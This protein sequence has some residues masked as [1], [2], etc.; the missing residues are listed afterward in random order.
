MKA[1]LS[2]SHTVERSPEILIGGSKSESNRLLIL[3]ALFPS[4]QINNLSNSDD[5]VLLQ[6]A[7]NSSSLIKDIHHA[8]TAMRFLTAYYA[9]QTG[10]EVLLTGSERM[11]ERPIKILVDALGSLGAEISYAGK[12]G[13]PPLKITG[14]QLSGNYVEL[15]AGISSQFISALMLIAP[16]LKDGLRIKLKGEV[17]S[18]PYL[19]MTIALLN[20]CGISAQIS[21]NEIS[22]AAA[23]SI[24]AGTISVESDWSSASYFYSLIALSDKQS[25]TL[26][27]FNPESRQGDSEVAA[28]YSQL[29]ITTS[30]D[31]S[32]QGITL[33]QVPADIPDGLILDLSDTPDIA[34]TIAISCFGLGIG[35]ELSGLHTLKIKETDRLLALKTEL[36]KL[37]GSVQVTANSLSLSPSVEFREDVTVETY[38]DHRMAMAFAPLAQK[39]NIAVNDAGVVSKSFPEFWNRMSKAG[40]NVQIVR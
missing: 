36:E 15:D 23:N 34:Q 27:Y 39:V 7:L 40:L 22:I 19:E 12:E 11:K 21:N 4:L 18:K 24:A 13:F 17:T 35:C 3:Q 14:K 25:L 37:G 20:R 6:Q 8:G 32:G 29:G 31:K 9:S 5:T 26:R 16:S 10:V 1:V 38:Q 33:T 2:K 30:F 28:I